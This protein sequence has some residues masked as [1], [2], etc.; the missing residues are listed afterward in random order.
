MDIAADHAA[1]SNLKDISCA[2]PSG[3]SGVVPLWWSWKRVPP[4]HDE[5]LVK[6]MFANGLFSTSPTLRS[7]VE[8]FSA[9]FE[10]VI[11]AQCTC[12]N[13][14]MFGRPYGAHGGLVF[15]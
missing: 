3:P 9:G 14:A 12:R 5:A 2:G 6:K 15:F 1:G 11:D 10:R 4:H 13:I 8:K 7:G